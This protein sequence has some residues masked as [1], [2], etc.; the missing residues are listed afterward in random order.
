LARSPAVYF[1]G[2]D[3]DPITV[4]FLRNQIKNGIPF[5]CEIIN[6]TKS[7]EKYWV[8]IQ[9]QALHNKY[10]EIIKYFATEEDI[11][12]E[13]EF[14]Q[15][16][17]ESENRLNSIIANLQ[18][19]ILLED[20]ARKIVFVNK[21]FCELFHIEVEPDVMKGL[22]C[23]KLAEGTKD[24]FN[25]PDIF[26]K[27]ID[28]IL[29]NKETVI[30]EEISIADGRI[31]ERSFIPIK[32]GNKYDGHLWNY[33]DI[34]LKKKH[35]EILVAEREKYSNI[36]ANMNMGLLEVDNN[37]IIQL[38][39]QSFID[40]SGYNQDELIGQKRLIYFERKK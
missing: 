19:G 7:K 4:N 16:L 6:Y 40:M 24:Y 15:Q 1:K 22:D 25:E 21:K 33:E 39:N 3:S 38:A 34:T 11:T 36:I 14:N 20:E 29:K 30:A 26:L 32:S 37:D 18:S 31:F 27:R 2:P 28:E 13:K 17:I 35:K 8:R 12:F 23:N 9:G 5:S 10:G